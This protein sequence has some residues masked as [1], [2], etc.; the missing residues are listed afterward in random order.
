MR[1]GLVI[2]ESLETLSGGYLYDR[3]LV[4]HLRQQGDQVEIVSLPGRTYLKHLGDNFSTFLLNKLEQLSMDIL[5]QDE[6]NHPSLFWINQ[7]LKGRRKICII[8]IVHHLLSDEPRPG[9]QNA[10]YRSIERKYLDSVDGYVFNSHTTQQVVSNMVSGGRPGQ[11]AYPGGD[12][13]HPRMTSEKIVARAF[14]PGPLRVIFLGNIIRRKGLH[15]LLRALPRLREGDWRLI[16]VGDLDLDK[17]YTRQVMRLVKRAGIQGNVRFLGPLQKTG[18]ADQL[19]QSHLLVVPS[20]YEGFGIAYLEGMGFGLPAVA[21]TAGAAREIITDGLN[22]FL[23]PPGDAEALAQRLGE[24]AGNRDRLVV[25]SLAAR[26]RYLS[27]PTWDET[28]SLIRK[29][30]LRFAH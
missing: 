28:T 19:Q 17:A 20:H 1:L 8:S 23:V 5:I 10:L 25:M 9:W 18:L 11:V 2:Y 13:L 24:L 26:D 3:K 30:L 12:R 15:V 4:E 14:E 7:R 16:V 6:L 29:F 27:H 22:G 21:T